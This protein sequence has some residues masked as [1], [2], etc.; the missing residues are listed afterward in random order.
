MKKKDNFSPAAKL[1]AENIEIVEQMKS[2]Y[3]T[4]LAR[5]VDNILIQ[6]ESLIRPA[7]LC[8]KSSAGHLYFWIGSDADAEWK[9][10]VGMIGVASRQPDIMRKHQMKVAVY[11]ESDDSRLQV[12]R[13]YSEF[14]DSFNLKKDH[15]SV[16]I[17]L[18]SEDEIETAAL[19][20]SKMLEAIRDASKT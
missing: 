18:G 20:I 5:F 17:D 2:I 1:Y 10:S 4:E 19:R 15:F 6:A 13:L 11:C 8:R 3:E 16:Q 7:N 12:M 14:A 9:K